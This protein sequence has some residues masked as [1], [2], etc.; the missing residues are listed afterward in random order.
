MPSPLS[1]FALASFFPRSLKWQVCKILN[2]NLM[3]HLS[4]QQEALYFVEVRNSKWAENKWRDTN[5]RLTASWMALWINHLLFTHGGWG[6]HEIWREQV[7]IMVI[8]WLCRVAKNTWVHE[9]SSQEANGESRKVLIVH[10]KFL[11]RSG[12]VDLKKRQ[13]ICQL[14]LKIKKHYF[15]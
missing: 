15:P 13:N 8:R 5:S 11:R 1:F 14:D 10:F 9:V 7:E 3:L 4:Q 6:F 12:C 2:Q